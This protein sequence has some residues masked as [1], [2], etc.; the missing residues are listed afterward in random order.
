M[1]LAHRE[2]FHT[3]FIVALLVAFSIS[4]VTSSTIPSVVGCNNPPSLMQC[5]KTT[6][7]LS[8]SGPPY[9]C[10]VTVNFNPVFAS[11]PSYVSAQWAGCST[12]SCHFETFTPIPIASLTIQSDN[13]E[14]WASMPVA[15]TEIYG[16]TNH[17]TS[18]IMPAGVASA[19]FNVLCIQGSTSA[20][21][22]LRPQYSVDGGNTWNELAVVSGFLD[23]SVDASDCSFTASGVEAITVGPSGISPSLQNMAT[24]FRVVGFN[25]NGLGDTVI[26]NN[27]QIILAIQL[28]NPYFT[29]ING[30]ANQ[31]CL[32]PAPSTTSMTITVESMTQPGPWSQGINWIAIE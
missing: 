2:A 1:T 26:F 5:G 3:A 20:T 8:Q 19:Y 27:I 14:T 16:T 21:A 25:G 7:T 13:G 6:C 30:V 29:C 28:S 22:K 15:S 23:A 10:S 17:E 11:T 24:Q 31:S 9:F 18:I 32:G 12:A 4:D